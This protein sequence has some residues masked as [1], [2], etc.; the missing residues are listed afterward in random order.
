MSLSSSRVSPQILLSSTGRGWNGIDAEFLHVGRGRLHVPGSEKHGLGVHF[1]APVN[2]DCSCGGHRMRRVQ[3]AGDIDIVPAGIGGSWEDD[4]DC[5]ILS[6][7]LQPSLVQ[8][9]AEELGRD[10]SNADL[11]PKLQVRDVRIEAIAWA[12]K[13]D[14]EAATPSEPLYIDLLANALAVRVI[15]TMAGRSVPGSRDQPR[16]STRQLRTLTDFI[17]ANLDQKLRLVDLARVAGVS[18]TRLKILFRNATGVPVH[19]YVIRRRVEHA[20]ALMTMTVMPLSEVAVAAGFAHQGH[21][22]STMRRLIGQ[23]PGEIVRGASE[24]RRK[25]RSSV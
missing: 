11:V 6:L 25:P 17:E 23:T 18:V 5:R 15:E 9:V 13:A 14:M 4:A 7:S 3:K 16:L 21:M 24:F 8:Q 19:Q 10:F 20:R 22:T 2:A 12:I 1:G